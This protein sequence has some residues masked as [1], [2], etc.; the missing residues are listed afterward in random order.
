M[1]ADNNDRQFIRDLYILFL[2][3]YN[4]GKDP[5]D[6]FFL[7]VELENIY[8]GKKYLDN[9]DDIKSV[10]EEVL[11]EF[12]SSTEKDWEKKVIE[13]YRRICKNNTM[14][15]EIDKS[16][17][18]LSSI[19]T[20]E[21]DID[22]KYLKLLNIERTTEGEL[23]SDDETQEVSVEEGEKE[24]SKTLC[25]LGILL[26]LVIYIFLFVLAG[27]YAGFLMPSLLVLLSVLGY[28]FAQR[29]P[30]KKIK[31]K[32]AICFNP[33]EFYFYFPIIIID[34]FSVFY[35]YNLSSEFQYFNFNNF[36]L[37]FLLYSALLP[38][39]ILFTIIYKNNNDRVL[40]SEEAIDWTDNKNSFS[41][42]YLEIKS[43]ELKLENYFWIFPKYRIL[44]KLNNKKDVIITTYKMNINS[45]G[46]LTIYRY[47]NSLHSKNKSF[48]EL[49]SEVTI[50]EKFEK[51]VQVFEPIYNFI[52]QL[53]QLFIYKVIIYVIAIYIG[54][55]IIWILK[56]LF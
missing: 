29:L 20:T 2:P 47:I 42:T 12:N 15:F 6:T 8:G 30:T 27:R 52:K 17:N 32:N 34:I 4:R 9:I 10:R 46:V 23:D 43:I 56:Y 18:R 26:L 24:G 3:F 13:S 7:I 25:N 44:L 45:K 31:Y 40:L 49:L 39:I 14:K 1:K 48:N 51:F 37:L 19:K 21:G 11:G 53:L 35:Y 36:V 33:S 55:L 54:K 50:I 22:Y 28:Y 16:I 5:N 41:F 38:S